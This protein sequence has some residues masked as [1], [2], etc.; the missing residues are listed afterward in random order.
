LSVTGSSHFSFGIRTY[1]DL[2]RKLERDVADLRARPIDSGIAW[3]IA[4]TAL[5]LSE[6]FWEQYLSVKPEEQMRLFQTT[7]HGKPEKARE[8]FQR[9]F[10]GRNYGIVRD[11][12]DGSKHSILTRVPAESVSDTHVRRGAFLGHAVTGDFFP[13]EKPNLV[14]I[15]KDGRKIRFMDIAEEVVRVWNGIFAKLAETG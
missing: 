11:L 14:I 9:K 5:H 3:N 6:W 2:F 13:G 1:E 8:Q 10:Y 15:L 12:C 7:F 4:V